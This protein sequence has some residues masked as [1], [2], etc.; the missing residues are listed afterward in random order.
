MVEL[1]VVDD[2]LGYTGCAVTKGYDSCQ[3]KQEE[4]ID[5]GA[6]VCL[7]KQWFVDFMRT[8]P[9]GSFVLLMRNT[10]VRL[11]RWLTD[12]IDG[13][14]LCLFSC[15]GCSVCSVAR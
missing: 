2:R 11:A 13:H 8:V 1:M 5:D 6:G 14:D 3:R 9:G 4:G 10:L 15:L 12:D 7:F